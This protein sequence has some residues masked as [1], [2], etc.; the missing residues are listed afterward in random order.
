MS[1][2]TGP[3]DASTTTACLGRR[4]SHDLS[5]GSSDLVLL[6]ALGKDHCSLVIFLEG[7]NTLLNNLILFFVSVVS[8]NE[9]T[10][11]P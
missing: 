1:T 2:M 10:R 6:T 8:T 9:T 4:V 3:V 11:N 7:G 5:R